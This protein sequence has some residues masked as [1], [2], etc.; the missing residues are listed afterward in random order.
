MVET[1]AGGT[2]KGGQSRQELGQVAEARDRGDEGGAGSRPARD[3][4]GHA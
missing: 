4:K 1:A 3:V 2:V